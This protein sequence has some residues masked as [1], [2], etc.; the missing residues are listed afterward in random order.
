[1]KSITVKTR[2]KLSRV[3]DNRLRR[4][5]ERNNFNNN[6][7]IKMILSYSFVWNKLTFFSFSIWDCLNWGANGN[8]IQLA[9]W[10]GTNFKEEP[11][12][13]L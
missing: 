2:K 9:K 4:N 13:F 7:K 8:L 12:L 1:M 11:F 6:L 3:T 5:N 10:R